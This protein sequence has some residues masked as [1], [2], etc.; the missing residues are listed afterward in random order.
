MGQRTKQ[1]PVNRGI[2][3]SLEALKAMLKLL[4]YPGNAN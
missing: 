2:S 3:N 1:I 4:N